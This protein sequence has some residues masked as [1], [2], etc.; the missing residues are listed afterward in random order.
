MSRGV[1]PWEFEVEEEGDGDGDAAEVD[2]GEE[3]AEALEGTA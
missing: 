1:T 2:F 3:V